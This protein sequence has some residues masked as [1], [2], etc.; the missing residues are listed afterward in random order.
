M[1][2]R[3][4][5]YLAMALSA[6]FGWVLPAQAGEPPKG[7]PCLPDANGDGHPLFGL[8]QIRTFHEIGAFVDATTAAFGDLDGDGDNDAAVTNTSQL[9]A[10]A[11]VE[12]NLA[13]FMNHGDGVF[14]DPVIYDVGTEPTSVEL[15]DLDGDGDLDVAL[16][17][18]ADDNVSVLLNN[19][20]GT[21]APHVT[22]PVGD[23]SYSLVVGD[24][25]GDGD[26]DLATL[27]TTQNDV[28]VLKNNGNGSFSA[29]GT[30]FVGDVI[31]SF[32]SV[33]ATFSAPG[34][35]MALG[36]LDGNGDL[37][38]VVPCCL[39][40]PITNKCTCDCQP[41]IR[42]L[43]NNGNGTF[44]APV[45]Y[46]GFSAGVYAVAIADLDA[47]GDR[48]IA[49]ASGYAC[50]GEHG[51]CPPGACCWSDALP[52]VSILRNNGGG[53]FAAP[54]GYDV[55]T[56][57]GEVH[58]TTSLTV[59]DLDDDGDPDIGVGYR[60]NQRVVVLPNNGNGIFGSKQVYRV[61]GGPW[62]VRA[63]ELNGDGKID[64]AVLT[65]HDRAKLS[66]LLN[67]GDGTL[68]AREDTHDP[69]NIFQLTYP[70]GSVRSVK[71]A[72]FDADGDLDLAVGI[73]HSLHSPRVLILLNDGTGEFS[74]FG[75]YALNQFSRA[76][77]LAIG[78][79]DGDGDQDLVVSDA[80][81]SGESVGDTWVLL[82]QGNGVFNT[83]QPYHLLGL[84]PSTVAIGDLDGD[85]DRDVVVWCGEVPLE[86]IRYALVLLNQGNGVLGAPTSYVLGSPPWTPWSP[87]GALA[88]GDIDGDG[89]LDIAGTN[90]DGRPTNPGGQVVTL[91]NN[92]DGT[93]GGMTNYPSHSAFW[94]TLGD[95]DDDRDLDLAVVHGAATPSLITMTNDG[96][97]NF[98]NPVPSMNDQ[99]ASLYIASHDLNLDGHL[100]LM[101]CRDAGMLAVRLGAGDGSFA[102]M[103]SYGTGWLM[104]DLA[105]GDFDAD[106]DVD[107]VTANQID[108]NISLLRGRACDLPVACPADIAPPGPGGGN[109]V[110]NIDDLLEVI[111]SWGQG[112][113][114]PADIAPPGGDNIVNIDDLLAVINAWGP[115]D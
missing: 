42:I 58:Q 85:L 83:S 21:L 2:Q 35:F 32:W 65:S 69:P 78:D 104:E 63:A 108:H 12:H 93:F 14:A 11:P 5:A 96:T 114:N 99:I 97:G 76:E 23:D 31:S 112:N 62:Y 103:V 71:S 51:P 36:D 10:G 33:N 47:D 90:G 109:G 40:D 105:I 46:S 15:A 57:V 70:W 20:D 101:I 110:V 25:D 39:E 34:P 64:M 18:V 29:G 61:F 66:L 26:R 6:L 37:D 27:S 74:I 43:F 68:I 8:P 24:L 82:N 73:G 84:I 28:R 1:H 94:L 30:F 19:G 3:S 22:Y 113:G 100:D 91:R 50:P 41:F 67:P 60:S 95:F 88:L 7:D 107:I 45:Q 77:R 80:P 75:T 72:D 81:Q 13:I 89:D 52:T 55:L 59:Q 53:V 44:G 48:D 102:P 56:D 49:V 17:N 16:I 38:L 98:T 79:L 54:V 9:V 106:G 87:I 92:G 86:Q 115:C 4:T 111:N